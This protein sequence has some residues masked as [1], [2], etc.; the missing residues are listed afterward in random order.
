[1]IPSNLHL[2]NSAEIINCLFAGAELALLARRYYRAAEPH[3]LNLKPSA[4]IVYGIETLLTSG[5]LATLR[6]RNSPCTASRPRRHTQNVWVLVSVRKFGLFKTVI[7]TC[8]L[9]QRQ[10]CIHTMVPFR[11]EGGLNIIAIL[12]I[13]FS[14]HLPYEQRRVELLCVRTVLSRF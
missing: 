12:R 3:S 13:Y 11:A 7:Y 6:T 2:A 9:F 5:D 14:S 4:A 1:M 8:H 10:S